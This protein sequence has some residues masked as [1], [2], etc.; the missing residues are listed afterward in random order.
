MSSPRLSIMPGWVFTD[1]R[2]KPMDIR[3]LGMLGRHIDKGGW[4]TRSQVK[5]AKEMGIARS[6]VQASLTRLCKIGVVQKREN[7]TDDGRDCSHDWRVLLDVEPEDLPG[8]KAPENDGVDEDD[9]PADIPAPPADISAPPADPMDRHPLPTHGPAPYK[10]DPL[11]T[12]LQERERESASADADERDG[13]GKEDAAPASSTVPGTADFEKRVMRFCNG[14]GFGSGAWPDWDTSSPGWV[15]KQFAKLSE[16]DRQHAE[17]WRDAYLRDIATR[18]K[19]PVPVGTF[20]RDRLWEG[21][22]PDLLLRAERAAEQGAKPAEHAKPDGWAN[23]MGPVWAA[24]LHEILLEGPENP[25]HA[26]GNGLWLRF[27]LQ[28]A[29]PKVAKLYDM[30]Q[31][32]RGFVAAE[33]HH[34]LKG[35]MEFVPEGS[36]VWREW[37]AEFKARGWPAW[38]RRDGMDGMYFPAA[39]PDG[40]AA[41][42]QALAGRNTTHNTTHNTGNEAAE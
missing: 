20:F 25:E 10:N 14:R 2:F 39:G 19:R 22:D 33:R 34:D 32:K 8:W 11:T 21:L 30:A 23:S 16:D 31:A 38:P 26:P 29:W 9:T 18:R 7:T 5:L 36:E 24:L 1:D 4:C 17:R 40:L 42:R 41:F 27:N 28:R 13:D 37:E 6:T 12:T 35:Q 15:A 3:I